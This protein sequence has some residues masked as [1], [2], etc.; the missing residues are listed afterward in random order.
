MS[1]LGAL[2][3]VL[4]DDVSDYERTCTAMSH[5]GMVEAEQMSIFSVIAGILHLGDVTFADDPS[6]KKG[7][8]GYIIASRCYAV[9]TYF[10][11][12]L[13]NDLF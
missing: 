7:T 12:C 6:D 10:V 2:T 3:D 9:P 5:M 11:T 4:R 8:L 1:K 13:C